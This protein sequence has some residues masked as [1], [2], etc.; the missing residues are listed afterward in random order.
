M[1][2][3]LSYSING[4]YVSDSRLL[5]VSWKEPFGK[6][7]IVLFM[8]TFDD[9]N[10]REQLCCDAMI[11]RV[12]K[13]KIDEILNGLAEGTLPNSVTKTLQLPY[14]EGGEEIISAEG[15]IAPKRGL[16]LEIFPEAFRDYH[17][18]TRQMLSDLAAR[19]VKTSRWVHNASGGWSP[20]ATFGFFWSPDKESWKSMPADFQVRMDI[21]RGMKI[22]SHSLAVIAQVWQDGYLEP[23]GHELVREALDVCQSNPR[24]ALLIGISAIE[25]GVKEYI[26]RLLPHSHIL[27]E[28]IQSPPVLTLCQEVIPRL[29]KSLGIQSTTFPLS[30]DDKKLIQ[31]WVTKRNR[32]AHG[33]SARLDSF[34]L[35]D[36]L[37]F[38]QCLLYKIDASH[39]LA[40]ASPFTTPD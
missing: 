30:E 32:V 24:S 8:R 17:S 23:L 5:P 21:G 35:M 25:T 38:G 28:K 12:P 11:E 3:K 31:K 19:F 7:E 27:L 9:P 40:W 20:F 18:E 2:F 22:D 13:P 16:H 26:H 37:K 14:L 10:I 6:G 29:H 34:K 15:K 4:M 39:G 1:W 33:S 36:F